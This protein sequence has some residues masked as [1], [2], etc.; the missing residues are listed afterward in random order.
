[1]LFKGSKKELNIKYSYHVGEEF[2]DILTGLRNIFE[3]V[4]FLDLKHYKELL[5]HDFDRSKLYSNCV[6]FIN[7]KGCRNMTTDADPLFIIKL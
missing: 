3:A 5:N 6:S 2:R 1:M 7:Y 4:I